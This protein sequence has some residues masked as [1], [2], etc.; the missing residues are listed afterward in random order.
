M[1]RWWCIASVALMVAACG[2]AKSRNQSVWDLYDV[3]QPVPTG[4]PY[5]RDNDTLYKQ[6]APSSIFDLD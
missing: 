4:Q 3:R 5:P 6:P 1:P 2:G